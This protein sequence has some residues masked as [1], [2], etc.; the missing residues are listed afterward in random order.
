MT[1]GWLQR[2]GSY[3]YNYLHD[4]N[5]DVPAVKVFEGYHLL[6]EYIFLKVGG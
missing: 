2:S 1:R 6:K 5:L 3:G 4:V